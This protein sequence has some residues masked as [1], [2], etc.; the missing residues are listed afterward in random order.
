MDSVFYADELPPVGGIGTLAGPEGKHAAT[1][2]RLRIGERLI[3][4]DGRG[5]GVAAEVTAVDK[6][7]LDYRVLD[8]FVEEQRLPQVTVVQG[9]PKSERSELAVDLATEAGADAIVPWQAGRS[10]SR[11]D[12]GKAAKGVARWQAVAAAAAKQSRRLR[13]PQVADLHNTAEVSALIG[14]VV[15][16][17][18]VALALHESGATPLGGLDL[19]ERGEIVLIIGPEGG[20]S[21]QEIEQFTAA[22]AVATV[23]GPTVLRTSTAAAVALGA[24]GV[25]TDRWAAAEVRVPTD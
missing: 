14:R 17:G 20:L 4:A 10:V 16:D 1:V 18:G 12:T 24:I 15:A 5:S 11:W 8:R 2:R 21:D 13:V 22:G 19:R 7:S 6:G 3:V 9:L 23:L 25:L